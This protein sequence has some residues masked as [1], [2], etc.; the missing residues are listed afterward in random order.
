VAELQVISSLYL[1][2]GEGY[3]LLP[4]V[5]VAEV[6]EYIRPQDRDGVPEFYLGDIV[7]RGLALPL[8]SFEVANG[9]PKP[10]KSANVRIAVLNSV[11]S[12]SKKLPF[13]AILTQG[14]PRLVKVSSEL[15]K[16]DGET[17]GPAESSRVKVDGE[18]AI[19]PNLP[20]LESLVLPTK[21]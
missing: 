2:I 19:I 18:P 20:Y 4:N 3:L 21:K 13:L 17:Q 14:I 16:E 1:P 7:W 8:I 9:G 6:V 5:S 10:K 12:D 15:I 11:G